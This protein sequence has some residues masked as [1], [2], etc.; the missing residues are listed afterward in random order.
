VLP[1][2]GPTGGVL[3]AGDICRVEVF[4]VIGG[5][6]AGVCRT[7]QVGNAPPHAEEI[8]QKLVECKYKLLDLIK[9]GAKCSDIY[10]TYCKKL[11]ALGLPLISF[12][13]HGGTASGCISTRIRISARCATSRWRPAWCWVS[14]L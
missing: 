2:V 8:W 6:H 13:G 10:R 5:Y 4:P 9:P 14:S 7:A 11:D 3:E 12:V 1:N